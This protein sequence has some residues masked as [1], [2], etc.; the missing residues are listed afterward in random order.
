MPT[1]D[2]I[3]A[4]TARAQNGNLTPNESELLE[5]FLTK[6]CKEEKINYKQCMNEICAPFVLMTRQ[7]IKNHI[8]YQYFKGFIEINMPTMFVDSV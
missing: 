6:Y 2:I 5:C 7:G 8:A 4:D 3:K 1:Q